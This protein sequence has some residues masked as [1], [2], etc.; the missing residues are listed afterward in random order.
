MTALVTGLSCTL[1]LWRA[2]PASSVANVV[3]T[4]EALDVANLTHTDWW[5]P[6]QLELWH[7]LWVRRRLLKTLNHVAATQKH[8][9]VWRSL[10][11]QGPDGSRL[12]QKEDEED[13]DGPVAPVVFNPAPRELQQL[14]AVEDRIRGLR[15]FHRLSAAR[16]A[17]VR[18][19]RQ[20]AWLRKPLIHR[21]VVRASQV[22]GTTTVCVAACNAAV[23]KLEKEMRHRRRIENY[24]GFTP[25][26]PAE[27]QL[28]PGLLE[29]AQSIYELLSQTLALQAIKRLFF[30]TR[31]P[32]A[33]DMMYIPH[34]PLEDVAG[35]GAAKA[36]A[37]EIIECLIAP[38]RFAA[39][40]AKCPKGLLLTG[41]PGCGKTMLARAIASAASVPFIA[42][43][44]ADFNQKYA[45]QG[46]SLVKDLFKTARAVAPAVI[47]IDE[48]DFIGRRRTEE[49]GGGLETDRSAAL[50]QLLSEMDGFVPAEGVVVIG[51][52]NRPDIL[53]KALLRPGRFDR[54]VNVPLPDVQGRLKILRK[55]A[56]R[57]SEEQPKPPTLTGPRLED[58]AQKMGPIDWRAWAKR[59]PGFSGADLAALV[60]EA[61][62][63]AARE[64]AN[65]VS[66]RHVQAAYSKAII[67]VPS[68]RRPSGAE[69]AITASHEA[70]H[71]VVNEVMRSTLETG[72]HSSFRTVAHISIVPA[73]GT[74]GVTQFADADEGKQAPSTRR[75]LLAELTVMMGGKAAE[76]LQ[77]SDEV[78]M[79][80]GSDLE[81]ATKLATQMVMQGGLSDVIGPRSLEAGT[82]PSEDLLRKADEEVR[83]LL[84]RAF[85]AAKSALAKNRNLHEAV[86]DALLENETLD[87]DAFR[88]IVEQHSVT[89][90]KF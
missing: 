12:L 63:A 10:Q 69:M 32:K 60:N 39:L 86:K 72:N 23:N 13:G 5:L 57:L 48:L 70:G 50:T 2:A 89:A 44:G 1:H 29:A 41:P 55:Q 7:K 25:P 90:V 30:T 49:H 52:T 20:V 9:S 42:K 27:V 54:K 68:T 84:Q 77:G 14:L 65:G 3:P 81:Q 21:A 79:G 43:S 88:R 22:V 56:K 59:T 53:D 71:A 8:I 33:K 34:T 28:P 67:G 61:A 78:T 85:V 45:G 31:S 51:T 83:L 87:G 75:I 24:E 46:S 64:E 11:K 15:H 18:A 47:L 73:G 16:A 6:S 19:S 80:A 17:A 36:E 74:G 62:L 66:E 37:V 58:A 82:R 26:G 35:I 76:A 40:G 38:T 4:S